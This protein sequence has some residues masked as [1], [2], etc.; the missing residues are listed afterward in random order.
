M[1]KVTKFGG[2]SMADAGQ[3]K[4]VKDI[5]VADKERLS[6]LAEEYLAAVGAFLVG[7]KIPRRKIALGV[8]FTA[9][10]YRL[11]S[12]VFPS[13]GRTFFSTILRE[14]LPLFFFFSSALQLFIIHIYLHCY[15]I[16]FLNHTDTYII[17]QSQRQI[18]TLKIEKEA[19]ASLAINR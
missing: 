7:G 12:A 5:V 3:L 1:L 4:K 9:V 16:G 15:F 6:L 8:F 17:P 14:D 11:V 19:E 10:E 2:S 18:W 13:S